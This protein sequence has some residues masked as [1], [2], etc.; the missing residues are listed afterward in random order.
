MSED[1]ARQV[2]LARAAAEKARHKVEVAKQAYLDGIV[3]GFPARM[4]DLL[5]EV[6]RVRGA[7]TLSLPDGAVS[8]TRQRVADV[9]AKVGDALLVSSIRWPAT[10]YDLNRVESPTR[11]A[12]AERSAPILG[13]ISEVFSEAGYD[14][15]DIEAKE[16]LEVA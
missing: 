2:D 9:A 14:Y 13:R 5:R 11:E 10:E 12:V 8:E 4:D 6:A 3:H 15:V 16:I 7:H 1:T